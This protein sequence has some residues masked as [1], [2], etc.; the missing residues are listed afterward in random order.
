[1]LKSLKCSVYCREKSFHSH[2]TLNINKR[3]SRNAITLTN[4]LQKAQD[5]YQLAQQNIEENIS[6]FLRVTTF[7]SINDGSNSASIFSR[8]AIKR[9]ANYLR[10]KGIK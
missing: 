2:W 5:L 3:L 9:T 1:M 10:Y 4:K 8:R 7:S 6:E